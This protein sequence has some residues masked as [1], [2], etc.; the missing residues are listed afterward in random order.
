MQARWQQID[1]WYHGAMGHAF[2]SILQHNFAGRFT[3][4]SGNFAVQVGPPYAGLLTS[5]PV[6]YKILIDHSV[7]RLSSEYQVVA[8]VNAL[9]LQNNSVDVI[10]LAHALEC[11]D[12]RFALLKNCW[13]A[14]VPEGLLITVSFNPYSFY[15]LRRMFGSA[16]GLPWKL[17]LT[18]MQQI[19]Q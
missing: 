11:V 3:D 8:D 9:P 16:C 14:L 7:Q 18:P 19:K 13:E 6:K 1:D 4:A 5:L 17:Q 12:H 15:G 10:V 2:W